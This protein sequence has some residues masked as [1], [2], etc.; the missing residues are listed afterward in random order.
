[1][2]TQKLTS[3][4]F[5]VFSL[6][7]L[8][9]CS[10]EP[11]DPALIAQQGL[12]SNSGNSTG[13][14]TL[15]GDYF[16]AALNNQWLYTLNGASQPQ[17]KMVSI[18]NINGLTYYTFSPT[19]ANVST[20]AVSATQRLRKNSGDY[21]LKTEDYTFTANG[22]S[23]TTTGFEVN[24]LKDYLPVGGSWTASYSQTTTF[25]NPLIPVITAITTYTGTI[26]EKGSTV[27]VGSTT[28]INVIKLKLNQS[29]AFSGSASTVSTDYWFAKNVGLVKYVIYGADG[30]TPQNTSLLTSYILN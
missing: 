7:L 21:F 23:G 13:G 17:S 3:A 4:L 27:T 30:T 15:S 18:D 1:M 20:T 22:I 6:F 28:Y 24:S 26:L 14:A 2:G 19:T 11:I 10:N 5:F 29:V 8:A 12:S 25:N 16:P 9:S